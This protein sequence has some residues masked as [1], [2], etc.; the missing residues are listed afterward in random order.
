M[1]GV[2]AAEAK[3]RVTLNETSSTS[4]GGFGPWLREVS[5]Q[6][7]WEHI[8]LR[9]AR[10][11]LN[12]V[13]QGRLKKLMIFMPPRHGK[14]E[15]NTIR[16]AAYRLE[17]TPA[18]KAMVV[19]Y[20]QD[21]ATEFSIKTKSIAQDRMELM[22]GVRANRRWQTAAGGGLWAF[23][24]KGVGGGRGFDLIIGDDVIKG[25]DEANSPRYRERIWQ[26]WLNDISSRVN[27]DCSFIL[28]FT[29]WHEDDLAGRILKSEDGPNWTVV[30]LPALAEA[31]DPM[32]RPEGMALWPGRWS[33]K[34]LLA[35]RRIDVNAFE[36]LYQQ[37]PTP[38]GGDMF[39]SAWF[40][41]KLVDAIPTGST[42]V[43]YWDKAGTEG[44]G[45]FTAGVLMAR[46]PEGAYIVCDVVRGQWKAGKRE[47]VIR[48]TAESDGPY[49]A[50]WLEQEPGSGG[51]ES[52]ENTVINLAGFDVHAEPVRGDKSLR[53]RPM[54]SQAEAGNVYLLRDGYLNRWNQTFLN[55]LTTFPKGPFKDQVDAA[56]GA[57]NK[58]A[59]IPVPGQP[60]ASAPRGVIGTQYAETTRLFYPDS[61]GTN[62]TLDDPNL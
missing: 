61:I 51:K 31:D 3:I 21:L 15:Q 37:N 1:A 25:A 56:S 47:K 39:E 40:A 53:A 54:A 8:H 11:Y 24:V 36:S 22:Q 57:F 58:L 26:N 17:R 55:E 45:A 6:W 62:V 19:S 28:T 41:G 23:G 33:R 12:E 30:R 35:R 14:T 46:T 59:L 50:V 18:L 60:T 2:I 10:W 16:Y 38:P 48:N 32:G 5:P 7:E 9:Y 42:W 34:F 52:A 29:R 49:T 27:P 43:R 4:Q 44:G 20:N 13:T